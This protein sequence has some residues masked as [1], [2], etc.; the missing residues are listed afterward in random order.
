MAKFYIY[1]KT[2][3]KVNAMQLFAVHDNKEKAE[4]HLENAR[5]NARKSGLGITY[6]L[7]EKPIKPI[8]EGENINGD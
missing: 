4:R 6:L 8:K 7:S 5:K 2:N 3:P 1:S